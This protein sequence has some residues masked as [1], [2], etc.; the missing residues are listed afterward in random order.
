MY[1]PRKTGMLRSFSE[2][3]LGWGEYWYSMII[4]APLYRLYSYGPTT[5]GLWGGKEDVDICAELTAS[6]STFW[7]NHPVECTDLIQSKFMAFRVTVELM[8]YFLLLYRALLS[9]W[10]RVIEPEPELVVVRPHRPKKNLL[11]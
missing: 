3:L 1:A 4:V 8:V 2:W 5:V 9:C 11:R 10:Q 6:P 7:E